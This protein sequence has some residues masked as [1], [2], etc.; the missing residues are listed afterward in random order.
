MKRAIMLGRRFMGF[1]NC[2]HAEHIER[3][4]SKAPNVKLTHMK[5]IVD[6]REIIMSRH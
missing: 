5:Q 6:S 4:S 3:A 2:Q 1:C